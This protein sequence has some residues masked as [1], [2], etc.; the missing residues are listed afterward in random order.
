VPHDLINAKPVISSAIREFFGSSQLSELWIKP[1]H[2]QEITHKR[3]ISAWAQA[4]A[5][6]ER[7][8]LWYVTFTQRITAVCAR[9]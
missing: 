6:R 5:T 1:I 9:L 4:V 8:R 2:Y 3:R 7:C